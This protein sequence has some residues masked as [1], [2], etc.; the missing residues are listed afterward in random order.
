M[1]LELRDERIYQG[2]DRKVFV[3]GKQEFLN[4]FSF[5]GLS[6]VNNYF[7]FQNMK[8]IEKNEK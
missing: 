2:T 3:K 7:C 1:K 5:R 6:N 8:I 4:I